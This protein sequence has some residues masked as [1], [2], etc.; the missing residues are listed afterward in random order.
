MRAARRQVRGP[1][2]R[3]SAAGLR[4]GGLCDDSAE[5]AKPGAA[6][7]PRA[8]RRRATGK[9]RRQRA[10]VGRLPGTWQ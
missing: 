2:P 10:D 6:P 7:C 9:S 5:N 8:P 4:P 1:A 3:K